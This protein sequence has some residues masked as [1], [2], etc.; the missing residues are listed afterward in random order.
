MRIGNLSDL[1]WEKRIIIVD[2]DI[3]KSNN[4]AKKYQKEPEERDI[5]IVFYNKGIAYLD[6]K[7]ISDRFS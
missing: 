4:R 3:F 6:N 2:D 1:K 5:S 7:I